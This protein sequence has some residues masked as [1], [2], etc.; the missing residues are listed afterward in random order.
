MNYDALLLM[1]ASTYAL[2]GAMKTPILHPI[3]EQLQK[4]ITNQDV[5]N[6]IYEIIIRLIAFGIGLYYATSNGADGGLLAAIGWTDSYEWLGYITTAIVI[7]GGNITIDFA[8][9]LLEKN[10]NA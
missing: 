7:A 1:S 2:I 10:T 3:R 5:A 4:R 6:G 9:T 8:K